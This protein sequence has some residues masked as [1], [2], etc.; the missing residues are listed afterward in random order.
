VHFLREQLGAPVIV[1]RNADELAIDSSRI[2]CDAVAIRELIASNRPEEALR[3][4]RGEL[5]PSFHIDGAPAFEE[6]MERERA[7]LRRLTAEAADSLAE[8]SARV[9]DLTQAVRF[10]RQAVEVADDDERMLRRL[11]DLLDRSGDRAGA[12]QTYQEFAQQLASRLDLTPSAETQALVQRIRNQHTGHAVVSPQPAA[13]AELQP[14]SSRVLRR[15]GLRDY[16]I[17]LSVLLVG[18]ALRPGLVAPLP[19]LFSAGALDT[20]DALLVADFRAPGPDSALGSVVAEIM[21]LSLE[22]SHVVAVVPQS[23]VI[24]ALERMERSTSS[25]LSAEL[26]REVAIRD[27]F[28]VVVAGNVVPARG[29][30]I[31][32]ANLVAASTGDVLAGVQETADSPKDIV[33]AVDR[34]T[35]NLRERIG[36]S[37]K[38][39]RTDAPFLQVST[40][41]LAALRKYTEAA[42]AMGNRDFTRAVG[43][44]EEAIALDSTFAMAYL[45]LGRALESATLQEERAG[46]ANAMAYRLRL[47]LPE[48]ERLQTI[49]NY[50]A[51]VADDFGRS[52]STLGELIEKYPQIDG[53]VYM[54]AGN[55]YRRVR[56][57]ARAESL[58]ARSIALEPHVPDAY[59]DI[60]RVQVNAGKI[61]EARRSYERARKRFPKNGGVLIAPFWPQI[62]DGQWDSLEYTIRA[63]ENGD[64]RTRVYGHRTMDVYL[65]MRGRL[66][67]SLHELAVFRQLNAARGEPLEPLADSLFV[68]FQQEWVLDH[69]HAALAVIERALERHPLAAVRETKRPYLY[70][71]LVYALADRPDKARAVLTR[72]R[73]EVRDTLHHE[74]SEGR[75][76]VAAWIALA[77]HR[78]L[79]AVMEFRRADSVSLAIG[80]PCNVCVYPAVGRAFD[81]AGMPDSALAEFEKYVNTP[82]ADRF[83][84]DAWHLPKVLLRM[85][86]LYEAKGDNVR[87]ATAYRRFI[88]LW[89]NADAPLQPQVKQARE[90]LRVITGMKRGEVLR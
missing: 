78:P 79:D 31:L 15:V 87:A 45:Y 76:D 47:R 27:G 36:E 80:D 60:I 75:T 61:A 59:F 19:S 11:I 55:R 58:L 86:E 13:I 38:A 9:G 30:Y 89:N 51:F 37:I 81:A 21:R 34:L 39:V 88:E 62:A 12:L 17:A 57:Y 46:R 70:L 66:H 42:R 49:A 52:A 2:F 90:R 4:Y 56:Q 33:P 35:R 32:S 72:F 50:E 29:G 18:L 23:R 68:A 7:S 77:E 43:L 20:N 73:E 48:R 24:A 63:A 69:K 5:L 28:K 14:V 10:A 44:L 74:S 84:P 83:G 40:P 67:E 53:G 22:R 8:R 26:A 41:S 85:G 25:P 16:A 3:L 82:S 54:L 1:S 71:A 64:A 65:L 6:W